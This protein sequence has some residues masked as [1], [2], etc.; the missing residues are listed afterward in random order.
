MKK[1]LLFIL[2]FVAVALSSC[3][4][5]F[6][7]YSLKKAEDYKA[8]V[9]KFKTEFKD[10]SELSYL[11]FDSKDKMSSEIGNV[12]FDYKDAS[13]GKLMN[14]IYRFKEN[15]FDEPS[16]ERNQK[17]KVGYFKI[18]DIAYDAMPAAFDKA[19]KKII[20]DEKLDSTTQFALARVL[21]F[22]GG[23]STLQSQL[24]LQRGAGNR[25]Y[26]EYNVKVN[27][28]GSIIVSGN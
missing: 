24:T 2:S 12:R 22:T 14:Q 3:G 5:A 9:E 18:S 17:K 4:D 28:D 15:K 1:H 26:F 23:S 7:I 16:E 10:R 27:D 8:V 19:C 25:E 20:A 21:F 6:K 13:T 11:A